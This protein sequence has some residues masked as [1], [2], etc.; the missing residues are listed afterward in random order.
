MAEIITER[1]TCRAFDITITRYIDATI[2]KFHML[3]EKIFMNRFTFRSSRNEH[4]NYCSLYVNPHYDNPI[5]LNKWDVEF[6][7]PIELPNEEVIRIEPEVQYQCKYTMFKE[8]SIKYPLI[9]DPRP[10]WM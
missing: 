8:L 5:Q 3:N 6:R 7:I 9:K 1:I 10:G 2:I 4:F